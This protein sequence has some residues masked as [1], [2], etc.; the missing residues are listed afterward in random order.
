MDLRA[1]L[2]EHLADAEKQVAEGTEIIAIQRGVIAD[3]E[4][5]WRDTADARKVL[6]DFEELQLLSIEE[7][8]RL[9]KELEESSTLAQPKAASRVG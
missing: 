2:L 4:R 6:S 9:L 1:I 8:D 7:R 3:L 5:H